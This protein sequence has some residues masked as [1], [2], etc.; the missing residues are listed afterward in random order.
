MWQI[1]CDG[2]F[3]LFNMANKVS[4]AMRHAAVLQFMG[5]SPVGHPYVDFMGILL[6]WTIDFV[7]IHIIA[8]REMGNQFQFVH[9]GK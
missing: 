7:S 1:R 9:Y 2:K 6:M 3:N 8:L 5:V 4:W